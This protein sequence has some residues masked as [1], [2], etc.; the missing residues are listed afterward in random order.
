LLRGRAGPAPALPTAP[1]GPLLGRAATSGASDA[2][3]GTEAAPEPKVPAE[4]DDDWSPGATHLPFGPWLA[5]AALEL[6]LLGPAFDTFL[7]AALAQVLTGG[8]GG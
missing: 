7:P 8:L 2:P 5:L 3:S 1:G 6:V 4:G